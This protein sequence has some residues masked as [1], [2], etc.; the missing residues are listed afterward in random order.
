MTKALS[1]E[2]DA[3]SGEEKA[4][5]PKRRVQI[6]TDG[7]CSGNPGPGGWGAIFLFITAWKRNFAAANR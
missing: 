3:G 6:W 7:A 5:Q 1:S 2:G 4:S